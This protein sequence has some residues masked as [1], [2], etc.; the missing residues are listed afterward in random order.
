MT[1]GDWIDDLP[2]SIAGP[3]SACRLTRAHVLLP[4]CWLTD[5]VVFVCCN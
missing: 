3:I 2:V 1:V 4:V 5:C